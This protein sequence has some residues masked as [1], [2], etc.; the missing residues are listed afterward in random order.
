[1]VTS[2]AVPTSQVDTSTVA[3]LVVRWVG[4]TLPLAP[5][6]AVLSGITGHAAWHGSNWHGNNWHRHDHDHFVHDH[7]HFRNRFLAVGVGGWW[8][9]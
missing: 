7:N 8:P 1:M 3:V 5:G 9:G 4:R 6:T 2:V